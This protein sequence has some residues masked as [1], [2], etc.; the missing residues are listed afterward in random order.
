M[1]IIGAGKTGR[2]AAQSLLRRGVRQMAVANRSYENAQALAQGWAGE[3]LTLDR[4]PDALAKA[5]IVISCTNAPGYV[6]TEE[7]VRASLREHG[8][9]TLLLIDIAVPATS[10][11]LP[12]RSLACGSSTWKTWAAWCRRTLRC[13]GWTATRPWRSSMTRRSSSW[14]GSGR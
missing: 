9:R 5:D 10:T 1:L 8:G 3:S 13:A 6:V 14:P 4:L 2:L 11:P 12:V 7:Q